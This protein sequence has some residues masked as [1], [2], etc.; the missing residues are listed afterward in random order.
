MNKPSNRTLNP[1]HAD[2]K[3]AATKGSRSPLYFYLTGLALAAL[4][5]IPA[6]SIQT[7]FVLESSVISQ[8]KIQWDIFLMPVAVITITGLMI[9]RIRLLSDLLEQNS[10]QQQRELLNNTSSVVYMKDLKGRYL[11]INRRFEDLFHISDNEIKGK[12]DYDI[13][14]EDIADELRKNDKIA[15]TAG[16]P[17]E[18]DET[19]N[20]DDGNHTYISVKFPL[21]NASGDIYACCGI[22]T[23]ITERIHMEEALRRS[24]KMDAIGQLTGGIAHDFNNQLGVIIGY[25]EFLKDYAAN[26]DK[27]LKWIKTATQATQRCV[28]LTQQLLAFSRSK[29]KQTTV[30]NL[31]ETFKDMDNMLSHS[32]TPEVEIQYFLADNLWPTE[33]NLGEFQDVILNLVINARDAMPNG[34]TLVIETCNKY[35]DTD[36]TSLNPEVKPGN[37]VQIKLSDTGVGMDEETQEHA[38][39]PFFTTKPEGEGTGLGLSMVYGFTERYGGYI[40]VHSELG[41]GT[42]F[43]LHLPRSTTSK[44]ANVNNTEESRLLTGNEAI[45]VVDDEADLLQLACQHLSDLGYHVYKAENAARALKILSEEKNIELLFSDVVMPGG[46]NGYELAQQATQQRPN[47]KVLLTSGFTSKTISQNELAKFSRHL[48]SKPYRKTELADR[49]RKILD[50]SFD[51]S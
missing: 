16:K 12:T 36:D 22:S 1:G 31:N 8:G 39:E 10:E 14:P 30:V 28:D 20:Q 43:H 34:G 44:P 13:L 50:R 2:K 5:I 35:I 49:V 25:L 46:I 21:K 18:F 11:F 33:T 45:L 19:I 51:V 29:A 7:F 23:D 15:I 27:P 38:Y 26:D 3:P 17:L 6:A 40:K 48:L 37:Y 9:G 47:L 4:F 42:S 41:V 32:I 24:Q